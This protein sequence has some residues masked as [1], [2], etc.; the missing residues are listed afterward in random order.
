MTDLDRNR[1][2]RQLSLAEVGEEGQARLAAA[3]VLVIGAG[4]LGSPALHHLV[5]AGVGT[6]GIAEFDDVDISN[7]HR[8]TL[9]STDDIGVP[10]LDAAVRRLVSVNPEVQ[11]VQHPGR[12]SSSTSGELLA[13]YDVLVDGSDAFSTRY[14]ANDAAI[15]TGIPLVYASVNQFSGQAS[16][17]GWDGGPCYRC[18]FPEPPP[19]GLVPSCA[20]GG[21]LGVVPALL[22]TIQATETLKLILG[23]GETLSGRLL[24]FDA[25]EMEF[26]EL[27]I[28]R[29]PEC[30]TCGDQRLEKPGSAP[31]QPDEA[32][33]ITSSEL[34]DGLESATPPAL[35]DVREA[36]ERLDDHIGG[37][38]IP[39]GML[40]V[41]AFELDDLRDQSVVVYCA[42]GG[43]SAQATRLLRARGLDARSLR[44]GL[45]TWRATEPVS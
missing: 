14:A 28:D 13:T 23:I 6:V 38:H 8:Q 12:F 36:R 41:R 42:S 44:G 4:G 24:M 11:V 21:V 18:L 43:R 33:E 27:R 3:S 29:D 34:R 1:Y 25:L 26:R 30:V 19:P 32:P 5:A 9:F 10:K 16:V 20:E 37:R 2:A 22:G 31:A 7:L 35:L 17:F 15:Q 40:D 45:Q 39:L